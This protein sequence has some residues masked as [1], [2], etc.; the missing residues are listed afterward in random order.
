[1][2]LNRPAT[3]T[4][5]GGACSILNVTETNITKGQDLVWSVWSKQH[6]G[7][8]KV[9]RFDYN[10]YV[11]CAVGTC[12]TLQINKMTLTPG[13]DLTFLTGVDVTNKRVRVVPFCPGQGVICHSGIQGHPG[14]TVCFAVAV[15]KDM[16]LKGE[17]HVIE[18]NNSWNIEVRRIS[19][20]VGIACYYVG[21]VGSR[22]HKR[23]CNALHLEISTSFLA[24]AVAPN[25]THGP[26]MN[27]SETMAEYP[28]LS[29][30]RIYCSANPGEAVACES[31]PLLHFP[32]DWSVV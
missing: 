8:M 4:G 30:T 12:Y 10:A 2:E 29:S 26:D 14:K 32:A 27:V 31:R 18:A 20:R 13:R 22:E 23:L 21:A 24:P 11:A 9:N 15:E 28:V 5:Y 19:P 3:S 6:A 7:K 1:M 16:L 25:L 17:D